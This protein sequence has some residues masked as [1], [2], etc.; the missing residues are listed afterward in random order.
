MSITNKH[1][2]L[3]S[4]VVCATFGLAGISTTAVA[5][6]WYNPSPPLYSAICQSYQT[7]AGNNQ[8]LG[9][10]CGS[11]PDGTPAILVPQVKNMCYYLSDFTATNNNGPREVALRNGNG[12]SRSYPPNVDLVSA[13]DGNITLSKQDWT[14]PIVFTSNLW[15]D[16]QNPNNNVIITVSGYYDH[17]PPHA[18]YPPTP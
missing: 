9:H 1:L 4:L 8:Y 16:V 7:E 5:G 2:V 12:G 6:G 18:S 15:V 13:Y 14:T 11:G 17:C 10:D 3:A